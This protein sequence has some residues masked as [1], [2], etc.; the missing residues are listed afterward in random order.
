MVHIRI[1]R[2]SKRYMTKKQYRYRRYWLPLPKA[3]GDVLD[4]KV[5]Y[6]VQLFGPAII[7]LPKGLENFFSSLEKLEKTHRE[8][9]PD[10]HVQ[11][12]ESVEEDSRIRREND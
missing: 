12:T 10:M 11:L 5:D 3:L 1:E 9:T 6:I 2:Y 4:A 7:F 8:N